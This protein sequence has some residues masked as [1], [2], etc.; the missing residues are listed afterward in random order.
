M[1]YCVMLEKTGQASATVQTTYLIREHHL[2]RMF[3]GDSLQL[4]SGLCLLDIFD[5]FQNVLDDSFMLAS[6]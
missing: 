6:T 2:R 4:S 5:R 1:L 3:D